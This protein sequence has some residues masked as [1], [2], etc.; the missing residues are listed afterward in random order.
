MRQQR[1]EGMLKVHA[2]VEVLRYNLSR[3]AKVHAAVE[4]MARM[5]LDSS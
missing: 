3:N 4:C 1:E 5:R 2:V